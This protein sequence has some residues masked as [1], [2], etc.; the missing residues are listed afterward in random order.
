[1]TY[2]RDFGLDFLI[3]LDHLNIVRPCG[4]TSIRRSYCML[5]RWWFEWNDLMEWRR[6]TSRA[7]GGA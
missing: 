3:V 5:K 7:R 4:W 1:V 2:G 6:G